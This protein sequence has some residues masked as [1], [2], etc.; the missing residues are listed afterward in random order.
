MSIPNNYNGCC[1]HPVSTVN[2]NQNYF[3]ITGPTQQ[4]VVTVFETLVESGDTV[5]LPFEP[6]RGFD[7][8]VYINGLLQPIALQVDGTTLTF[9]HQLTDDTVQI[10]YA[11]LVPDAT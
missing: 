4:A 5:T 7:I 9:P 10:R 11:H 8:D 6:L 2:V 3:P 1:P